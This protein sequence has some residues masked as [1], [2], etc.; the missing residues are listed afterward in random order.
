MSKHHEPGDEAEVK[1]DQALHILMEEWD[2]IAWYRHSSKNGE[3]DAQHTDF[4]IFLKS[5][6]SFPLQVKSSIH[7]ARQ[8]I[9]KYPN[10]MVIYVRKNDRPEYLAKRVKILILRCYKRIKAAPLPA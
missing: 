4:L 3:L 10:I 9:S 7:S 1:I 6:F 8:H 5:R 2:E